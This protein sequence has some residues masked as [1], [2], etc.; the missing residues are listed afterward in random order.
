M[1]DKTIEKVV[2]DLMIS[3][4]SDKN[5]FLEFY[6]PKKRKTPYMGAAHGTIGIL[7]MMIKALQVLP[8]LQRD[9]DFVGMV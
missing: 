1:I 8:A 7:Y 4:V 2:D 6:F 9:P 3:G 5:D